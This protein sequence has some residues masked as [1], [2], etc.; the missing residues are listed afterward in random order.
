MTMRS[1]AVIPTRLLM[2]PSDSARMLR[3]HGGRR[4][5]RGRPISSS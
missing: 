1:S 4:S 2:W 5:I 3:I